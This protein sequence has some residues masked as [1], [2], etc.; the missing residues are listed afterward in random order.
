MKDNPGDDYGNGTGNQEI[1]QLKIRNFKD[2]FSRHP[3]FPRIGHP[4]TSFWP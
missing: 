3:T 1:T 2:F 4:V